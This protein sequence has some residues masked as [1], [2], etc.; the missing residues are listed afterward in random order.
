MKL[1]VLQMKCTLYVSYTNF[2][3]KSARLKNAQ[4]LTLEA[5]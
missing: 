4:T 1:V 3:D 2:L 5:F